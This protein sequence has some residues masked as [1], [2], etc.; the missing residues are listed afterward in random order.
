[1][2]RRFLCIGDQPE[3]GG[4][5]DPDSNRTTMSFYGHAAAMIGARAYCNACQSTGIIAKAGGP[6]RLGNCGN[7]VALDGDILRCQ[8]P[9]LPRMVSSMQS[10][11]THDDGGGHAESV[12]AVTPT[13]VTY[14]APPLVGISLPAGY[15]RPWQSATST[16]TP[17]GDAQPFEYSEDTPSDTVDL[18]AGGDGS[19]G[20]NQAQ[21][22]QF[23]AVVKALGLDKNQTRQLHDEISGEGLGY[24][25]ILERAQDMFGE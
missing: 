19:P 2:M 16:S 14:T 10:T 15:A 5:I 12:P 20:N 13:T 9:K 25:E 21:N 8:C 6:K 7:E 23:K 22:K 18:L 3:T 1:M 4:S 24:H 17:L 11:A